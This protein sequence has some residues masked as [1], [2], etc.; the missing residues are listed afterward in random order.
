[1]EPLRKN[2]PRKEAANVEEEDIPDEDKPIKVSRR[3]KRRH[4]IAKKDRG[5]LHDAAAKGD[6]NEVRR[7]INDKLYD[8]EGEDS[9]RKRPI[10]VA[11]IKNQDP[12]YKNPG[13]HKK[14]ID[15]LIN[16]GAKINPQNEWG[17]TPVHNC[18][19]RGDINFLRYFQ[20]HRKGG[21]QLLKERDFK[22]RTPIFHAA[23][24]NKLDMCHYLM[25]NM[26]DI[27]DKK[28][29]EY[30][31][32]RGHVMDLDIFEPDSAGKT[33][34]YEA[35]ERGV[36]KNEEAPAVVKFLV[37]DMAFDIMRKANDGKTIIYAAAAAGRLVTST[38]L[39]NKG[40][41]I[42]DPDYYGTTA[43]HGAAELGNKEACQYIKDEATKYDKTFNI[44]DKQ[45]KDGRTAL[46]VAARAR[47]DD[48]CKV[49]IED[50]G[51]K[52]TLNAKINGKIWTPLDAAAE[53]VPQDADEDRASVQTLIKTAKV[54]VGNGVLKEELKKD[55]VNVEGGGEESK[56]DER[57]SANL[58]GPKQRIKELEKIREKVD[59]DKVKKWAQGPTGKA[60]IKLLSKDHD[61][62]D[63]KTLAYKLEDA[64]GKTREELEI[65][66]GVKSRV[67]MIRI[68]CQY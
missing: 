12:K 55:E 45:D 41:N 51:A 15:L 9:W 44:V 63:S 29:A 52:V 43:L 62:E 28:A 39:I 50:L 7:L 17:R 19:Q 35:V 30:M 4:K 59:Q 47:M 56:K 68:C 58:T 25:G 8:I 14:T 53:Y 38:Y 6:T 49:L 64:T 46:Y 34:L 16:K 24:E 66:V 26:K 40:A 13:E 10:H 11:A 31:D 21:K 61:Q 37:E 48:C 36:S 2:P 23:M 57:S 3:Q 33:V 5:K 54:L 22:G 27:K 67:K 60:V 18:A 32:T 42:T 65:I 1:M 20:F